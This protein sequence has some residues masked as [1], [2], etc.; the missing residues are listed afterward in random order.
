MPIASFQMM[1]RCYSDSNMMVQGFSSVAIMCQEVRVVRQVPLKDC[2]QI[3]SSP[4]MDRLLVSGLPEVP[5]I[6]LNGG[7]ELLIPALPVTDLFC[8]APNTQ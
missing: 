5:L 6:L 4:M 3:V 7:A 1:N 2:G 8:D